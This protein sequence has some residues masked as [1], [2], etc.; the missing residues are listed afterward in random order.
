MIAV[1]V[2]GKLRNTYR[3]VALD[4][5]TIEFRTVFNEYQRLAGHLP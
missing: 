5:L 3:R 4:F 2:R 1:G